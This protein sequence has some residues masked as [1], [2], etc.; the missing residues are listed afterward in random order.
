MNKWIILLLYCSLNTVIKATIKEWWEKYFDPSSV[1]FIKANR[2]TAQNTCRK[3]TKKE[4]YLH[5]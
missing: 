3:H 2:K 1:L 4:K 5:L